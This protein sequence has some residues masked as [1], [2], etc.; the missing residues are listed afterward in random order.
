MNRRCWKQ[1]SHVTSG[2]FVAP[3]MI[4]LS[5]GA[6]PSISVSSCS[7]VPAQMWQRGAQS[8]RKW[9]EPVHRNELRSCCSTLLAAALTDSTRCGA[10]QFL[11]APKLF[12]PV[13]HAR[14]RADESGARSGKHVHLI[15]C[16][17]IRREV[18]LGPAR[19]DGVDFVDEDDR[20]RLGL[21][22]LE[23]IA[24]ACIRIVCHKPQCTAV[25]RPCCADR[26]NAEQ[27]L[28]RHSAQYTAGGFWY[29]LPTVYCA[30]VSIAPAVHATAIRQGR[31]RCQRADGSKSRAGGRYGARRRPQRPPRTLSLTRK[32]MARSPHPISPAPEAFCPC[33]KRAAL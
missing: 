10:V 25:Q 30:S 22:C 16:L 11:A 5:A 13:C 7:P 9:G 4:T 19:A 1:P 31:C 29:T 15:E 21:C 12:A 32:R 20:R 17:A 28:F 26:T 6:N 8:R 2:K 24:D 14:R 23:E 18:A 3:M 33:L 27:P